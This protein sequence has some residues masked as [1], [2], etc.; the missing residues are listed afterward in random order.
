LRRHFF[1]VFGFCEG[2]VDALMKRVSGGASVSNFCSI[3]TL[4]L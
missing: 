1:D 4:T 2:H 3:H